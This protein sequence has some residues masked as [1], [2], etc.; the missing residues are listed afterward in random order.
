V[1]GRQDGYSFISKQRR[2]LIHLDVITAF[3]NGDLEE[4]MY[5]EVPEGF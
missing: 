1:E 4:I 3:L 5:M 2:V